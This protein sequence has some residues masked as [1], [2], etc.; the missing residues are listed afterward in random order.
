[1]ATLPPM[2]KRLLLLALLTSTALLQSCATTAAPTPTPAPAP[3]K[4]PRPVARAPK[5]PTPP[6]EAPQQAPDAPAAPAAPAAAVDEV[7]FAEG[8]ASFYSDALA[9]RS[10]ANG[11]KY[12][13]NARTCAH[14]T[15]PFGTFVTV[16]V[17]ASGKTARC[18]I[19][20]RGP[21]AGGRII[22]LS[23]RVARELGIIDQGVARVR[24]RLV[25]GAAS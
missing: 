5:T 15:L 25:S 7:V 16:E 8:S 2:I 19:N 18:R 11:E 20:D 6:A 21:Y 9:G 3:S 10:T 1:M 23:R 12:D 22:D 17:T 4:Q 14:R 13:P 24:V